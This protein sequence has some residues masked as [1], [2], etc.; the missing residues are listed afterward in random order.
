[1]KIGPHPEERPAGARLE[2]RILPMPFLFDAVQ[3]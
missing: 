3:P 2:G 1:M